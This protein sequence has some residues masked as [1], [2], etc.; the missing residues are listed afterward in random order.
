MI[1]YDE[2]ALQQVREL[3]LLIDHCDA[4]LFQEVEPFLGQRVLEVGCGLGN[5]TRHLTDRSLVVGI[6][7]SA[8]SVAHVQ[9]QYAAHPNLHAL[10]YDVTD[11]AVLELARFEFD[12]A[13]MLNV[14]EHIEDD[15]LALKH[16]RQILCPGGQVIVIVPAHKWLY[17]S[18][19]RSIGHYRRYD[20]EMMARKMQAAG[21]HVRVQEHMNVLGMLGWF[22]NGRILKQRVPPTGQLKLFNL[23]VP[24]VQRCERLVDLPIGLSLLSVAQR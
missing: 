2:Y 14:L 18:M 8:K 3:R 10:V 23:I 24:V 12:T 20:K 6:D 21:F 22:I 4:W 1:N 17:G 7:L 5:L 9:A 16:V 19:D 11:P 13:I 15:K